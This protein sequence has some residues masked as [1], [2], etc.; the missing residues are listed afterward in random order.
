MPSISINTEELSTKDE[1]LNLYNEY[2]KQFS[3]SDNDIFMASA[4]APATMSFFMV[5]RY[6]LLCSLLFERCI[7][8]KEYFRIRFHII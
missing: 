4:G 6:L 2:K 8:N 5:Y 1:T 3:V 7:Q